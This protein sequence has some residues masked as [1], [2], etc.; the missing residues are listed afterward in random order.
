MVFI[1]LNL[2]IKGNLQNANTASE[3]L[4]KSAVLTMSHLSQCLG[5][6]S[7]LNSTRQ[8]QITAIRL[9]VDKCRFLL[10]TDIRYSIYIGYFDLMP[11]TLFYNSI[12]RQVNLRIT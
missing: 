6:V 1:I 4:E 8:Q 5:T 12:L 9:S 7:K 2:K 10:I 11:C 3:V